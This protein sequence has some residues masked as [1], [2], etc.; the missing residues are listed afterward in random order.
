MRGE[1]G[2]PSHPE[3]CQNYNRTAGLKFVLCPWNS[4]K[5]SL[6]KFSFKCT[7]KHA[8]ASSSV[9]SPFLLFRFSPPHRCQ[10]LWHT[11]NPFRNSRSL[12]PPNP[13]FESL[14]P[15]LRPVASLR[16]VTPGAATEGVTPL[17][18]FLKNLFLFIA[19]TITIAFYCFHS[20][21]TP[22]RVSPYTF[23]TCPTSFLHYSL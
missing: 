21:V 16:W 1:L 8:H 23:F 15:W 9:L 5:H 17:F 3:Q 6:I 10:K 7:R 11:V 19:V 18:Y 22:S 13:N 2:I 12:L 20:G 14:K 4:T